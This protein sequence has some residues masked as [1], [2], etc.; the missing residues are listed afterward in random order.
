MTRAVA[1]SDAGARAPEGWAN[2]DGWGRELER[3]AARLDGFNAD[4]ER[5]F[6]ALGS[7]LQSCLEQAGRLSD[8]ARQA[9]ETV[10]GAAIREALTGLQAQN[11]TLREHSRR[12]AEVVATMNRALAEALGLVARIPAVGQDFQRS[13]RSLRTL[14]VATQVESARLGAQG[15]AFTVL[16]GE[17]GRLAEQV[18]EDIAGVLGRSRALEQE[19]GAALASV[20]EAQRILH[21]ELGEA[22]GTLA[23][24]SRDLVAMNERARGISA[25]MEDQAR[26]LSAEMGEIVASMQFQDITRQRLEHVRD[27]LALL[28]EEVGEAAGEDDL[29]PSAAALAAAVTRLQRSQLEEA[30][31]EFFGALD[32]I[33]GA[34]PAVGG[35]VESLSESFAEL[36]SATGPAGQSFLDGLRGGLASV[37][38]TIRGAAARNAEVSDLLSSAARTAGEITSFIAGIDE[39]GFD[40]ELIAINAIVQSSRTGAEGRPLAV[41]A[42]A[43]QGQS[44]DARRITGRV[45]ALLRGIGSASEALGEQAREFSTAAQGE[46][47]GVIQ[48]L[49][50]LILGL[51]NAD[52]EFRDKLNALRAES[53][54][55]VE[56]LRAAADATNLHERLRGLAREM[57]ESLDALGRDAASRSAG[58]GSAEQGAVLETLAARYTMESQR[59]VHRRLAGHVDAAQGSPGAGSLGANVEL[60]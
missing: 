45:S 37:V 28:G 55:L 26:K 11:E 33:L 10:S 9:L 47:V 48:E 24:G 38:T 30:E 14:G 3:L 1:D 32:G 2:V 23:Q 56:E 58:L 12:G 36:S 19:M 4:S 52:R 5:E 46:A 40:I 8:A 17:V 29:P 54:H 49:E 18:K 44:V 43:I 25:R 60:F 57:G 53:A 35:T 27:S 31:Q 42:Q 39:I 34:L 13:V 15:E 51:E 41:I 16:A 7:R 20:L 50:R 21:G 6:P 22:V 59:A